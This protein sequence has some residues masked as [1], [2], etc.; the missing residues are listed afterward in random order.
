MEKKKR[1]LWIAWLLVLPVVLV[2]GFTTI[3][4]IIMTFI[5]STYDMS[6]LKGEEF[7]FVG[8]GN[9]MR[10]LTD[11]KLITSVKFTA[12]FTI[13][14]MT[15]HLVLG[16]CLALMLNMKF[17]GKKFLRTIVLIPWAMPMVVA[18][19][20]A[21]WAFNDTYG[22]INDLIRRI[23]PGFHFDWLVKSG[24]ARAA[25]IAVDLWKDLPFFAI[26]VLAALQFISSDIYEA[27]KIDGAGSI[28]AFFSITLPNIMKT[29]LSL[30]I[31]FTLWRMTSFDLVY[32]MT[33]G[34]PGDSTTL[35]AYRIMQEAFTNLN[36]GYAS[37][38]AV[39]LFL[40][41]VVLSFIQL[42]AIKKFD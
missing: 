42:R 34:G 31:F 6:L 40:V 28:R 30:S 12:I 4:P 26:L 39:C 20:A 27:A 1:K 5:N 14:S 37:A 15:F 21:R 36:L 7:H 9:Y 41:M 38:I 8:L 25:V 2:R 18:G 32:A 16:V 33:S 23:V 24:S 13:V 35:V 22:L 11:P 3:Y 17:K 29:I 10:I 19:L